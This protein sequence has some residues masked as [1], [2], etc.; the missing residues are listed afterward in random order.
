MLE[1]AIHHLDEYG[2]GEKIGYLYLTDTSQGLLIEP[3]VGKLKPGKHGFHVHEYANLEPMMKNGKMIPGLAAGQHYDPCK[4]GK[5][6]GPYGNGHL[7][8]LPVLKVN[9]YGFANEAVIAPRLKLEDIIGR[10][11]IIHKKGDNYSD[12]PK[13]NGGGES[14]IAGGVVVAGCPYCS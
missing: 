12:Y 2:V 3:R 13:A 6:C 14:R 8:D 9:R 10:S 11:I 5:H 7:G 1:M 4:T